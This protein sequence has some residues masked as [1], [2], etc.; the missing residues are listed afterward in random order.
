MSCDTGTQHAKVAVI[1]NLSHHI[2][3]GD[4]YRSALYKLEFYSRKINYVSSCPYLTSA[5]GL[6]WKDPGELRAI[7]STTGF[8]NGFSP[9]EYVVKQFSDAQCA[10]HLVKNFR[11]LS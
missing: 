8:V 4:I 5:A 2:S 7:I 3:Y 9:R 11:D 1:N 10:A 6:T